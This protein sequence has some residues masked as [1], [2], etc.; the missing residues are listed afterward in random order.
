MEFSENYQINGQF[1]NEIS[2]NYKITKNTF[3]CKRFY[4]KLIIGNILNR[5]NN[6]ILG[7]VFYGKRF[8][9]KL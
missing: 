5:D 3:T 7:D 2:N 1:I 9:I 8:K 6:K 4:I